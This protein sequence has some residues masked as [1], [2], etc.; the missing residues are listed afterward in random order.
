MIKLSLHSIV[1]NVSSKIKCL[2]AIDGKAIRCS[3]PKYPFYRTQII[4][5]HF[6]YG[7]IIAGNSCKHFF[8]GI[9]IYH[10]YYFYTK[11]GS[12]IEQSSNFF[13]PFIT[14]IEL[15]FK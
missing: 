12:S 8:R 9:F 5:E 1:K 14:D 7:T 10:I 3:Q 4:H 2:I 11:L 6:I 13:E 15:K